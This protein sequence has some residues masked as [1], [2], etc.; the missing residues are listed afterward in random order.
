MNRLVARH[1]G[2]RQ[3]GDHPQADLQVG[4]HRVVHLQDPLLDPLG[5]LHQ[6][7]R[8]VHLQDLH[9]ANRVKR[10]LIQNLNLN[11]KRIL[12]PKKK[13]QRSVDLRVVAH[14]LVAHHPVAH[15]LVDPQFVRSHLHKSLKGRNKM[16]PQPL[17]PL[18]HE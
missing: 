5:V 7:R 15:P 2:V 13:S 6:G 4:G 14:P 8:V 9:P 10:L 12:N 11:R 1:L 17:M 16:K 3:R 18:W